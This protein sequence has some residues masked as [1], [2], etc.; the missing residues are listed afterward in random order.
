AFVR[1]YNFLA[2]IMPYSAADWEKLS[3]F[4]NLLV[5]KLPAPQEDDLSR[6]IL[7]TIDMESYRS[8]VQATMSIKLDDDDAEIDPFA[9]SG[10]GM[11]IEPETDVLSNIIRMF[12][13]MYGGI[14]WQ[15]ADKVRKTVTEDLPAKVSADEAYQNAMHH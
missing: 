2:S 8:E 12:N 10:G 14:P 15:D 9:A 4:L 1:A 5:L 3:I 6:G 7:E 11:L 13:D